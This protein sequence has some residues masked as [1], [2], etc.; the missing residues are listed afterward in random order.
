MVSALQSDFMDNEMI[1]S[2]VEQ[3]RNDS[4]HHRMKSGARS[5]S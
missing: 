3:L 5:Q 2:Q 4:E 1:S